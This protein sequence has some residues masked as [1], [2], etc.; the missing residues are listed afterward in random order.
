MITWVVVNEIVNCLSL[1]YSS[2][3]IYSSLPKVRKGDCEN[4]IGKRLFCIPEKP[5]SFFSSKL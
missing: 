3:V 2:S 4:K 1:S 5:L